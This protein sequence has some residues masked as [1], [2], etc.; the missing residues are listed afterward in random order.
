MSKLTIF[1]GDRNDLNF[2]WHIS[3]P[4]K[5]DTLQQ[6]V[7][8]LES[9]EIL[10]ADL[11][12][13]ADMAANSKV[14]LVI[15]CKNVISA[16]L[17]VPNKAQKLLRKAIPYMIEDDIASSVDDLFFALS[18]KRENDKL[19]VRAVDKDY[20]ESLIAEFKSAELKLVRIISDLDLL[21]KPD[22]GM[23]LAIDSDT[24]MLVQ[25]DGTRWYCHRDDF[26]WLI[27][28]ELAQLSSEDEMPVAIPLEVITET[29]ANEFIRSL[30]VGRFS[31]QLSVVDCLNDYLV[32]QSAEA[33][34]L[35]QSEYEPKK[36]SS[37]L[38]AFLTKV[39][40]LAGVVLL[41]HLVYQGV[42]IYTLSE[43]KD[44][45]EKRKITLF[46][47]A[48]PGNKNLR[49]PEKDMRI[50]MKSLGG[51]GGGGFLNLVSSSSEAITDLT[52]I[53]PTNLNYDQA[54][55]ELRMDVIASDLVVLD[56]YADALRKT[57]HQVEK[58]SE[59]Q[60]GDGYSSRLIISR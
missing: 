28:K 30:P 44:Q 40:T 36:E 3:E 35:L 49:K 31:L 19:A 13:M 18:D 58:S 20:L 47:Q 1:W 46:K 12:C 33:I 48:F 54:K 15:S 2:R 29:E 51:S 10:K 8:H 45:L 43:T 53:Y 16:N 21:V 57:G 14:T 5:V 22:E 55:N 23:Q 7:H 11:S 37:K 42:N 41:A 59:T 32:E 24:C 25:L 60:R 34:N 26:H 4:E 39:A 50:Y 27:Q 17:E 52:K 38:T 9:K 56:Q 6:P